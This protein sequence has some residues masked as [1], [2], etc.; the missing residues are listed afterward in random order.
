[1]I[2]GGNDPPPGKDPPEE[3]AGS[4]RDYTDWLKKGKS[5]VNKVVC[6][7]PHYWSRAQEQRE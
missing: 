6:M 1:M 3:I 2:R 4:G 5:K 7:Y